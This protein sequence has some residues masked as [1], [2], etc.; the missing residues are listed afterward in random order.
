MVTFPGSGNEDISAV[1]VN[2][3]A[4]SLVVLET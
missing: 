4:R 2:T 1:R 3:V